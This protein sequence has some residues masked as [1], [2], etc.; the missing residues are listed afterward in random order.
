MERL[1]GQPPAKPAAPGVHF[2]LWVG[3]DPLPSASGVPRPDSQPPCRPPCSLMSDWKVEM[4][5]D[6]MCEFYVEFP[7]PKESPYQGGLWKVHG[8]SPLKMPALPLAASSR[9]QSDALRCASPLDR[10]R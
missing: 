4:C 7:G 3:N 10:A 6:S 5:E 9:R 8:T 1:G 2:S